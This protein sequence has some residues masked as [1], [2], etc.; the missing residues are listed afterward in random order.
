MIVS[1]QIK[2]I[3]RQ[4]N[5]V[6]Y[7]MSIDIYDIYEQHW[8]N[9]MHAANWLHKCLF[10]HIGLYASAKY[11]GDE[12]PC[13]RCVDQGQYYS[14]NI[15]YPNKK[16]LKSK[17]KFAL[18]SH[19]RTHRQVPPRHCVCTSQY[20]TNNLSPRPPEDLKN[21]NIMRNHSDKM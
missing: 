10:L 13:I 14:R 4:Y 21:D 15:R 17:G 8:R 11:V 7:Q 19:L 2:Y 1:G 5:D 16:G 18:L 6:G 12:L 3:H 9:H 20:W